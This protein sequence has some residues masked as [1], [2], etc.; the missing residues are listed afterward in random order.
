MSHKMLME[1]WRKFLTES[2]EDDYFRL[3]QIRAKKAAEDAA[4]AAAE[5]EKA[6]CYTLSDLLN[7]IEEFKAADKK[8]KKQL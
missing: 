4:A 6:G 1:N 2:P 7:Y 5:E 8:T 3:Q